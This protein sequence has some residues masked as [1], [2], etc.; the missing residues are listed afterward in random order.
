MDQTGYRNLVFD[1]NRRGHFQLQ[2]IRVSL[3][4]KPPNAIRQRAWEAGS[5]SAAAGS[6]GRAGWLVNG[7]EIK[8]E[9]IPALSGTRR[10]LV[11]SRE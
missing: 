10:Y 7:M 8:A 6:P 11:K 4:N 5:R 1:Q 2:F 3:E 9:K